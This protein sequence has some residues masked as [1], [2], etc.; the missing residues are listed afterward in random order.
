ML[1][2]A[3]LTGNPYGGTEVVTHRVVSG[4][5]E[6]ILVGTRHV[7]TYP[8]DWPKRLQAR[9]LPVEHQLQ[10][11]MLNQFVTGSLVETAQEHN[12]MLPGEE[13]ELREARKYARK[14]YPNG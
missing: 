6:G 4:M 13:K 14:L 8:R 3:N 1:R 9:A 2:F 5:D 11:D 7:P 10:I 12:F